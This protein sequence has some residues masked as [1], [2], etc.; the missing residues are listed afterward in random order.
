MMHV[1]SPF[2]APCAPNDHLRWVCDT[3]P[4]MEI[5]GLPAPNGR[6]LIV[7]RSPFE[8]PSTNGHRRADPVAV[9]V[10]WFS[11]SSGAAYVFAY[12]SARS[13]SP[14]PAF[15]AAVVSLIRY[16]VDWLVTVPY[17]SCDASST[18]VTDG[19]TTSCESSWVSW[20]WFW[21]RVRS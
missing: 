8:T 3:R 14:G 20:I 19:A 18:A 4:V 9:I 17:C 11:R 1:T 10:T 5:G 15:S 13:G 21:M 2:T 16:P 7:T 6:R 12:Q